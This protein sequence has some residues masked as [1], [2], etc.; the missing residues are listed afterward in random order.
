MSS[1]N[2]YALTMFYCYQ[3]HQNGI[4]FILKHATRDFFFL[5]IVYQGKFGCM[6]YYQIIKRYILCDSHFFFTRKIL[7]LLGDGRVNQNPQLAVLHNV[8]LR[9]HNRVAGELQKLHPEWNDERL[10]QE[11]RR[12]VISEYQHITYKEWLP[13]FIGVE[14]AQRSHIYPVTKGYIKYDERIKPMTINSF[15]AAAYRVGHSGIQG[16]LR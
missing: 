13:K 6:T 1:K 3:S 14:F 10:Y 5:F 9:E 16:E 2:L 15:A 8:F 11:T 12:I 7:W 4:P